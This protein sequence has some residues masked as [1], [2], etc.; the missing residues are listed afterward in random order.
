MPKLQQTI[1]RGLDHGVDP[2][3]AASLAMDVG[4]GIGY[5]T[6]SVQVEG[7]MAIT[8]AWGPVQESGDVI[9]VTPTE[10]NKPADDT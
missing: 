8:F 1:E 5:F 7:A 2:Y 6:S 3:R 10:V 9:D 4:K